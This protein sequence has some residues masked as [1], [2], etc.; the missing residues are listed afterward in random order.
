MRHFIS[1]EEL[2][3]YGVPYTRKH[4]IDLQRLGQFPKAY[5]LTPNRIGW[6]EEDIR[7]WLASRPVASFLSGGK[8]TQAS[9]AKM[10][11]SAKARWAARRAA[12]AAEAEASE[13]TSS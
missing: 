4:L 5:Q 9:H 13:G 11:E 12:M 10:K 6:D 3:D 7:V 2:A 1:F 8:Y